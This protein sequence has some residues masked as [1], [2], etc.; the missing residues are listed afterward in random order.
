MIGYKRKFFLSLS[1]NLIASYSLIQNTAIA[2][3]EDFCNSTDDLHCQELEFD[4]HRE[5]E[6][7]LDTHR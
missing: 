2:E 4:N 5:N 3:A 6:T 7:N 1:I